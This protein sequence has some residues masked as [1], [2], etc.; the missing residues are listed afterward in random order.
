MPPTLPFFF[1]FRQHARRA[2]GLQDRPHSKRVY[3]YRCL[4]LKTTGGCDATA[5]LPNTGF[6]STYVHASTTNTHTHKHTQAARRSFEA[7]AHGA[8]CS[9]YHRPCRKR[10]STFVLFLFVCCCVTSDEPAP[11]TC[12]GGRQPREPSL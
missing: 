9:L 5:H 2:F 6:Q 3:A 8:H 1:F 12:L 11:L 4:A 7:R 10:R